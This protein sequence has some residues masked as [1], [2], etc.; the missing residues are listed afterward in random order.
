VRAS[1]DQPKAARGLEMKHGDEDSFSLPLPPLVI[2]TVLPKPLCQD[3]DVSRDGELELLAP[4]LE[5]SLGLAIPAWFESVSGG[6]KCKQMDIH[7][8]DQMLYLSCSIGTQRSG[9]GKAFFVHGARPL[10]DLSDAEGK[11]RG[12]RVWLRHLHHV[13]DHPSYFGDR[14]AKEEEEIGSDEEEEDLGG[15]LKLENECE[16]W[17]EC[18]GNMTSGRVH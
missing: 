8:Q 12:T 6:G 2:P 14:N 16:C 13:R 9:E 10:V 7:L 4:F 3:R 5:N 18:V 15:L 1:L 11:E 17:K